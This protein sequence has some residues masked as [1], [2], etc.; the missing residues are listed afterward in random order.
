M[1]NENIINS[2][3][4]LQDNI[5]KNWDKVIGFI[6]LIASILTIIGK[7][8]PALLIKPKNW[9]DRKAIRYSIL[10]SINELEN[11]EDVFTD[12]L[13]KFVQ[14]I[15]LVVIPLGVLYICL[16]LIKINWFEN[17]RNAD[18]W[19]ISC[20]CTCILCDI[21]YKIKYECKYY[22]ILLGIINVIVG[23][24]FF[25]K[26]AADYFMLDSVNKVFILLTV[27]C[28]FNFLIIEYILIQNRVD[29]EYRTNWSRIV[30]F[31]RIFCGS[32]Y[33][34]LIFHCTTEEELTKVGDEVTVFFFALWVILC[35]IETMVNN[36]KKV[37]FTIN[38]IHGIEITQKA[39]YQYECN[40]VKYTL[41]AGC[42][43][44]VDSEEIKSID[45]IIRYK[46]RKM[47][48]DKIK[49]FI[50]RRE[51][52][53]VTCLLKNNDMLNFDGYNFTK[54]LWVSFYKL[55]GNKREV[56]IINSKI[57]KK[58]IVKEVRNK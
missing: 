29:S 12:F 5:V 31:L 28:V 6:S 42:T 14:I 9:K 47:I 52:V 22:H 24:V 34:I 43:K 41:D 15:M 19:I 26:E 38:K 58:I 50:R 30:W 13:I 45:Y 8:L 35:Y 20:I 3:Q 1:F 2:I 33:I 46:I 39:I 21:N 54:D 48:W 40:K 55:N 57:I 37:K 4:Y 36:S 10:N 49:N 56:K 44:I 53:I 25:I 32:I 16:F 7:T 27:I 23:D 11:I 17:N 18:F 51:K